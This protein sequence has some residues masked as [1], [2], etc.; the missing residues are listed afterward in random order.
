MKKYIFKIKIL[1]SIGK[2]KIYFN[3]YQGNLN[4]KYLPL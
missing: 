3:T 4:L 2:L 1:V